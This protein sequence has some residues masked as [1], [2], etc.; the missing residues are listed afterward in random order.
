[1]VGGTMTWL[2]SGV[3]VPMAAARGPD[4]IAAAI[5]GSQINTQCRSI[6]HLLWWVLILDS[7]GSW[8]G[9]LGKLRRPLSWKQLV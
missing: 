8:I 6:C 4:H 7:L 1:M 5:H 9:K 3:P 2:I